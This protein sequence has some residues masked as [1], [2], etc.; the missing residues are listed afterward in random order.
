M[1]GRNLTRVFRPVCCVPLTQ[2]NKAKGRVQL[3]EQPMNLDRMS[4]WSSFLAGVA[5]AADILPLC[6]TQSTAANQMPR[7]AI[8]SHSQ[9]GHVSFMPRQPLV[10][11]QADHMLSWLTFA[12]WQKLRGQF[13][14]KPYDVQPSSKQQCLTNIG[15]LTSSSAVQKNTKTTTTG[16]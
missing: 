1:P 16:L 15:P 9:V 10:S 14:G 8:D 11:P 6:K 12:N 5:A 7:R 13:A 2:P 4:A 3:V